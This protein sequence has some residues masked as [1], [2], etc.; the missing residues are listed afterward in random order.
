M[1]FVRIFVRLCQADHGQLPDTN[2]AAL[3]VPPTINR[4][5]VGNKME[6]LM[7]QDKDMSKTTQHSNHRM[8]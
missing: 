3:L 2:T 5:G 6:K 7:S 1:M 8:S 4:T